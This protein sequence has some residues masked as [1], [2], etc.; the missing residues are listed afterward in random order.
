[1]ENSYSE[2]VNYYSGGS[3]LLNKEVM[4]E[5]NSL[6]KE[7]DLIVSLIEGNKNRLS[8]SMVYWEIVETL[9]DIGVK[10]QTIKRTPKWMRSSFDIDYTSSQVVDGFLQSSQ[11][12]ENLS[13]Q[14]GS[15]DQDQDWSTIAVG[16]NLYEE[17][18]TYEGDKPLKIRV[19]FFAGTAPSN[20]VD[21]MVGDNILGKD[22]YRA[23]RLWG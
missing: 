4:K 6:I 16:N 11:T 3:G 13:L 19:Q 5:L 17:G 7:Y 14:L 23:K 15:N 18:Y 2:I 20:S 12:V 8:I 1:M 22:L 9:D 21:V 10:L